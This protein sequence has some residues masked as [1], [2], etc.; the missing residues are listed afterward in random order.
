MF[1]MIAQLSIRGRIIV[2]SGLGIFLALLLCGIG[3]WGASEYGTASGHT[4]N[5][6]EIAVL[7]R[8]VEL[9]SKEAH[10]RAEDFILNHEMKYAGM[11][12]KNADL[13]QP[14]LAKFLVIPEALPA[15]ADIEAVGKGVDSYMMAFAALRN[16]IETIGIDEN[17][18]IQ[19]AFRDKAHAV[20]G[21]LSGVQDL[22]LL[23]HLLQLRRHEKDYLLRAKLEYLQKSED[24]YR[25]TVPYLHGSA[26]PADKKASIGAALE[27]YMDGL[28]KL[29]EIDQKI[30]TSIAGLSA[31]Y[32]GFAP[33]FDRLDDFANKG[34]GQSQTAMEETRNRLATMVGTLLLVAV[35]VSLVVSL[36]IARSLIRPI[37][38]VTEV[39]AAMAS[40]NRRIEVPFTGNR[41][42]IGEMARSVAIFK[43][44]LIK[45]E[46]LEEEVKA[47][48][49]SEL[50]RHRRREEITR[51]FDGMVNR[52]LGKV[53]TVV[54]QVSNSS[55]RMKASAE[56]TG[57]LGG[58]VSSAAQEVSANV[59]TVAAAGS[60]LDYAI[61]EVS[62]QAGS[63]AAN[64]NTVGERVQTAAARYRDLNAA[65]ERIGS[66]IKL[67]EDIA[68]QTNLLALNATIE[69]ARAGD[70]GKG[71]A[72]VA[73]EVKSLAGQT[74]RATE[75]IGDMIGDIQKEAHDGGEAIEQLIGAVKDVESAA[76]AIA[77]AIEEQVA[78]TKEISRSI[79][80]VAGANDDVTRNIVQVADCAVSTR[81]MA[82]DMAVVAND[83]TEEAKTLKGAVERFLSEMRAA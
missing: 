62:R 38:A 79:E 61:T 63:V 45:A 83:L 75:E 50:E 28:R 2:L 25:L 10:R 31:I 48:A 37:K 49:L 39:M 27:S 57:Q 47:K 70:A 30:R 15:R 6:F 23:N 24:E 81:G 53:G 3:F 5:Y 8:D 44:G 56:E 35:S 51:D 65:A 64:A 9:S 46:R 41:D 13:V 74:R 55:E 68:S 29:V 16:D 72:V 17:H 4:Q 77:A 58:A 26:L 34:V 40:G 32:D 33:A 7:S 76:V 21:T 14:L 42:E 19:G 20:E 22:T 43:D 12:Q 69:A 54:G 52:L 71:F 73:N 11:A 67:I 36:L 18:G 78:T 66:A 80:E 60:E 1:G 59:Q 82:V